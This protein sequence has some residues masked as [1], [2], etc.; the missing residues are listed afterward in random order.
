MEDKIREAYDQMGPTPEQEERMLAALLKTQAAEQDTPAE[1][2]FG[3]R[4][5]RKRA[6]M[7][8]WK[9]AVPIAACLVLGAVVIGVG[10]LNPSETANMSPASTS[11][12]A[13]K[14]V[15]TEQKNLMTEEMAADGDMAN[16]AKALG[17][18]E[19]E[20]IEPIVDEPFNTE[21]YAAVDENGFIST[22]TQPL[23]TV[24]ADVDTASYA[25]LRLLQRLGKFFG[26]RA[27]NQ[28]DG[29]LL[30]RDAARGFDGTLVEAGAGERLPV[31][32]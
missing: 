18:A 8:A 27:A 26:I 2:N 19:V 12:S 28:R 3:A 13:A 29:Q 32:P 1:T 25:N 22:R 20:P 10:A 31:E 30:R 9:V 6:P 5:A 17:A 16:E 21:E 15:T 4:P 14:A 11:S 24:S 7:R 23:S